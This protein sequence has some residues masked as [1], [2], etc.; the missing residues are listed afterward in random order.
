M[1]QLVRTLE[2]PSLDQTCFIN[3]L[4]LLVLNKLYGDNYSNKKTRFTEKL[5]INLGKIPEDIINQGYRLTTPTSKEIHLIK[6]VLSL[7]K[8]IIF[9]ICHNKQLPIQDIIPV[10]SSQRQTFLPGQADVDL[11]VRFTTRNR[12]IL[13][14]FAENII[15]ELANQLGINFEIRYAENPYGRIFVPQNERFF[16]NISASDSHPTVQPY[17][18]F[19]PVDI[20][21]TIWIPSSDDLADI[22]KIS[23]MARTPFHGF[24]L[25]K[26]IKGL[27]A[28]AR[29][30]KYWCKLNAFY[31]QSGFTGFLTELLTI[32]YGSFQHILAHANDI[33]TLC[34]DFHKRPRA[35]LTQLF[36]SQDIII[37]D[38]IDPNRNAAAGIHG[39][40]GTFKMARFVAQAD[41]A[42]D[43]P[44]LLWKK[45]VLQPPYLEITITFSDTISIKNDDEAYL[46]LGRIVSTLDGNFKQA[47]ITI[48]DALIFPTKLLIQLS[49]STYSAQKIQ[50]RGPPSNFKKN[51]TAFRL[52]HPDA[53]EAEG[54][55][56][57]WTQYPSATDLA[58]KTLGVTGNIQS[59]SVVKR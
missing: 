32:I 45:F 8:P 42:F 15:P 26:H 43:Q 11:F 14:D 25:E 16:D 55:Y 21:A 17:S 10:G 44:E 27:E 1:V 34:Y 51:I 23:G 30:F 54:Y 49:L 47:A 48:N 29:L 13:I 9:S 28:E 33:S 59:F 22:L 19:L 57:T 31:G 2:P 50:R 5:L 39:I 41:L 24:F 53:W 38:P 4:K 36:A 6:K 20:V 40:L 37:I 12:Q 7:I 52:K 35:D 46:R 18:E 3:R 56:W 58:I